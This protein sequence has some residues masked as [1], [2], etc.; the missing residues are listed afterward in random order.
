MRKFRLVC[1]VAIVGWGCSESRE[2][3]GDSSQNIYNANPPATT[4]EQ[5]GVAF[6]DITG[7]TFETKETKRYPGAKPVPA[8]DPPTADWQALD[9]TN[10]PNPLL[11]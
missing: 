10:A 5:N 6:L 3:G 2:D 7:G 1:L 9:L 11:T 8:L 4:A